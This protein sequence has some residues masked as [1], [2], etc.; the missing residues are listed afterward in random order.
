VGLVTP[1]GDKPQ[2]IVI[3]EIPDLES[4]ILVDKALCIPITTMLT[5][6]GVEVKPTKNDLW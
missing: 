4:F 6:Q 2:E 1:I 5:S 3:S